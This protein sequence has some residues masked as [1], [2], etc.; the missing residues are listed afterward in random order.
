MYCVLQQY[1]MYVVHTEY[2]KSTVHTVLHRSPYTVRSTLHAALC[3]TESTVHAVH[4]RRLILWIFLVYCSS[5][6]SMIQAHAVIQHAPQLES[7]C[8]AVNGWV[9]V[10]SPSTGWFDRNLLKHVA[11]R[12][13]ALTKEISGSVIK[14]FSCP[15]VT[16][17]NYYFPLKF[18]PSLNWSRPLKE[19]HLSQSLLNRCEEWVT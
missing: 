11:L 4:E 3:N 14:L 13:T 15:R 16:L 19:L 12:I 17:V 18:F 10:R 5:S 6:S 2:L 1:K 7:A 8:S 9:W